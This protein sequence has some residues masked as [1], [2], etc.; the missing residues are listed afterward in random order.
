M[1]LYR[2]NR[3]FS[4]SLI[5]VLL[6]RCAVLILFCIIFQNAAYSN[7]NTYFDWFWC[8]YDKESD[9]RLSSTVIRPFYLKNIYKDKIFRASAMPLIFWSYET[10]TKY[11]WKSLFGIAGALDYRH[12]NGVRDYDFGIFPFLLYGES[13]EEKDK[14]LH[15]WPFGGVIRGKLGQDRITTYGFPGL[16]LFLLYPP[17]Y[18][19]SWTAIGICIV[20]IFPAYVDYESRDYKAHG[21]FWPLVQWGKSSSRDDLRILPFYAHNRKENTYDNY[22][23]LTIFNYSRIF[24]SEDEERTIFAFPFYGRRWNISNMR[25][26]STLLWP[27]FSW[28]YDIKRG[29]SELN[30]PWPLVQIQDSVNP[31]L[32]K[33]IFFPLYGSYEYENNKMRFITPLYFSLKKQAK[34]FDSE[35]YINALIIWYFKRDYKKEA[36]PEYG[37]SWR[38]F[39][40]WPVFQCEYDDRGNSSI[41]LFS[42]LPFRDEDGYEKLYQPFWTLIEY[43]RFESGEK[44]IGFLFR[45]LYWRWGDN[46]MYFKIPLLFSYSRDKDNL[47]NISVLMSMFCYNNDSD[48]NYIRI[49]WIPVKLGDSNAETGAA[50]KELTKAVLYHTPEGMELAY[51]FNNFNKGPGNNI[52]LYRG[53]I[54]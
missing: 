50:K 15:I 24:M 38:Y 11:E 16:L 30:F 47:K 32:R 53:R 45:T 8:F 36:S 12:E 9:E 44:R 28:G 10:D 43:K 13:V 39:K 6:I 5:H 49:F 1:S 40:I 2:P 34:N 25:S 22:S 37:N 54:F 48:G 23:I 17:S 3:F 31:S 27:F 42:L 19:L 52:V 21:V 7:T 33:R 20:S 4:S 14:Y 35:Y 51:E 46:F 29:S 41:N 26:S 18:P